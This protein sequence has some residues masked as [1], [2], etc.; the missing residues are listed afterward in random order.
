MFYDLRRE[1]RK[2]QRMREKCSERKKTE[3][4]ERERESWSRR[5]D[6]VIGESRARDLS[7]RRNEMLE[8]G[9]K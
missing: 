3:A 8:W 6:G 2:T 9:E 4:K 1:A 7:A 5:G